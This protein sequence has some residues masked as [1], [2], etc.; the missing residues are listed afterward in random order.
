MK[1]YGKLPRNDVHAMKSEIYH[2]GPIAVSINAE[3]ILNYQGGIF[4]D[5]SADKMQNHAV[6]V[7][8]WGYDDEL[9]KEYWVVRN[10]WGE[11]WGEMGL[12]R[13]ET[14]KNIIGIEEDTAWVTPD[15]WTEKN[16]PCGE[17]G[18]GCTSEGVFQDPGFAAI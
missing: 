12:F 3:P 1:E 15:T 10:S 9:E 2:R 11:Y 5:E 7:V 14:G 13:V 8:G 6:S 16:F 18:E 4:D 17:A